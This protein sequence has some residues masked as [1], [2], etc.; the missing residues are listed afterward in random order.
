MAERFGL[1]E[2]NW[3]NTGAEERFGLESGA[4]QLSDYFA[5]VSVRRYQDALMVTE[6]EP[7]IGYV[8][9]MIGIDSRPQR[10]KQFATWVREEL[11]AHGT[12][13]ITKDS[14]LIVAQ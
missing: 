6:A 10:V 4:S 3:D 13:R 11:A 7:L 12:I 2:G 5:E 9:S 14:G 1:A 8:L